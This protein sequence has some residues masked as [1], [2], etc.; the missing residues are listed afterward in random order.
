MFLLFACKKN[1]CHYL[2]H[3]RLFKKRKK[4]KTLPRK[5]IVDIRKLLVPMTRTR[6]KWNLPETKSSRK[7]VIFKTKRNSTN[8]TWYVMHLG[9]SLIV[10]CNLAKPLE[11]H[12]C[13]IDMMTW[14]DHHLSWLWFSGKPNVVLKN[15]SIL[16]RIFLKFWRCQI[17]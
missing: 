5:G 6:E 3:R 11:I 13:L 14:D 12:N 1:H 8:H 4:I 17:S 9:K 16:D 7:D 2:T 10:Y 15:P